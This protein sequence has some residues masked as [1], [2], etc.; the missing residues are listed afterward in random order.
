ML[1]IVKQAISSDDY[2]ADVYHQIMSATNPV[3]IAELIVSSS[4]PMLAPLVQYFGVGT[5]FFNILNSLPPPPG[6][7]GRPFDIWV[8]KLYNM[9]SQA[10]QN[11][12]IGPS[13]I[14]DGD[15]I[16]ANPQFFINN[17]NMVGVKRALKILT[18][19]GVGYSVLKLGSNLYGAQKDLN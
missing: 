5:T 14:F 16:N 6:T 3:D 11:F 18:S 7:D 9:A 17:Y 1:D 15:W 12:D 13:G 4:L 10:G 2:P 8:R 19:L